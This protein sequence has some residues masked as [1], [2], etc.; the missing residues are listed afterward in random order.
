MHIGKTVKFVHGTH[1][2]VIMM[3]WKK[4]TS[5]QDEGA[6]HANIPGSVDAE[7]FH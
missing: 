3:Y 5:Y 6:V 7:H 2:Y 1:K 4:Q